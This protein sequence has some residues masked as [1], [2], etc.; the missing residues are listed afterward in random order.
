MFKISIWKELI[1]LLL[2]FRTGTMRKIDRKT[3]YSS[4]VEELIG[5]PGIVQ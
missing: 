1:L 2:R 5:R 4:V 3:G